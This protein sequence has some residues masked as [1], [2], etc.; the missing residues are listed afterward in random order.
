MNERLISISE[1]QTI[2]DKI[3]DFRKK[4]DL[5]TKTL[6]ISGFHIYYDGYSAHDIQGSLFNDLKKCAI[7][8]HITACEIVIQEL[9]N[10]NIDVHKER[11]ELKKF[12]K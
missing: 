3:E 6:K 9:S 12:K 10:M 8:F 2:S 4:L 11:E 7:E 5:L 1:I